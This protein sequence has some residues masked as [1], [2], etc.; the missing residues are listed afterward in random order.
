[1]SS[2]VATVMT[3]ASLIEKPVLVFPVN[4]HQTYITIEEPLA[5]WFKFDLTPNKILPVSI[6][7]EVNS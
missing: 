2:E 7:H 6:L 1:M 5:E 3:P 4:I